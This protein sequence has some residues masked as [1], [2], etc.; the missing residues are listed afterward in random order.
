MERLLFWAAER[1]GKLPDLILTGHVHNF[2]RFT[3]TREGKEIPVLVA[4][5]GGYWYLHSM[6][7]VLRGIQGPVRIEGREDLVLESYC[8]DRHGFLRL[9]A[10]AT[11]LLYEYFTVPRPHESWHSAPLLWDRFRLDRQ[12]GRLSLGR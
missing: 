3:L 12:T 7:P 8:D 2:Q 10:S 11:D 1:S 5:S 6:A 4:G 9:E